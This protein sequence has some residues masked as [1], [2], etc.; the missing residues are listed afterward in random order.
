MSILMII[1][2][3]TIAGV[4]LMSTRSILIVFVRACTTWLR[5]YE[6]KAHY[7][8]TVSFFNLLRDGHLKS[9]GN[10]LTSI[11]EYIGNSPVGPIL[12]AHLNACVPAVRA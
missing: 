10:T 3:F 6:T 7:N 9:M 11:F 12:M 8:L 5:L 4:V 1:A 2:A